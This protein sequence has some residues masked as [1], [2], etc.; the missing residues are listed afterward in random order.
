MLYDH[1][2]ETVR[3]IRQTVAETPS[4]AVILGSGLGSIIYAMKDQVVF[5]YRDLPY[6][7]QSTVEGHAG[8]LVFGYLG[9][10][11]AVAL[12]G[13]FHYYEG[14]TM[15]Q[16]AYPVYVLKMLGVKD[17]IV[18]NACGGI[19]RSFA[20]GD[21]MLIS[22]YI[23]I[24]GANP[25]I[26]PNDERFG[27]RF[28]D[29][30]E[31]FSLA[32]MDRARACAG[33]L[34]IPLQEGVYAFFNGPCFETAAEIRA[35]AAL[36]ADAIGMSTVPETT[37]AVYLGMRVLGFSCITNMA[38]GIAKTKHSHEEVLQV[39]NA[40]AGSLALLIKTLMEEWETAE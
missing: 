3:Y 30:S 32:L 22:D 28:P 9:N 29:C 18:T 34:E 12:A 39:A 25:L 36:G 26:G 33:K 17:L 5:P 15:K 4:V 37:A 40:S 38:T 2:T 16:V 23:N 11:F 10:T 8:Q 27:P 24:I 21:L 1:V 20:P 6:F 14:F 19:N 35:F 13:R 7:P 31:P